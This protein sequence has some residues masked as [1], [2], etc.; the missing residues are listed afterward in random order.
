MNYELGN[1]LFY[2]LNETATLFFLLLEDVYVVNLLLV[3]NPKN[4][5][6]NGI[7]KLQYVKFIYVAMRRQHNKIDL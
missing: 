6:T 4:N 2:H 7:R 5:L 3:R 1:P